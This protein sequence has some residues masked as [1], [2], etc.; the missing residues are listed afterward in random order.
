MTTGGV[1]S[2]VTVQP[3]RAVQGDFAS[4]NPRYTFDAG[5]GGVVA[6]PNGLTIGLFAWLS[7]Q[8]IDSDGAPAYANNN[9]S[10]PV[11]GLVGRQEQG[12]NTTYLSN[13]GMTIQAGFECAIFTAVDMWVV[14]NGT[15]TA[16]PGMKAYANFTNGQASF[17]VP[18]AP[19]TTTQ[20]SATV[21]AGT[22]A[23]FTGSISGNVLT[24]SSA[25]VNTLYLG[26]LLGGTGLTGLNTGVHIVA[27]LSGTFGAAGSTYALDQ[28]ELNIASEAMT[29]TPYTAAGTGGAGIVVGSVIT[30]TSTGASGTVVGAQV[31]AIITAGT[32]VVV[33]MPGAGTGTNTTATL[34]FAQNVETSW[35]CRSQGLAGE[36]VKISNVPALG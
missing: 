33:A 1:Q 7:F 36:L 15:T 4:N 27:L 23:T 8:G 2:Q 28:S 11:A 16:V 17:A 24:I 26:A 13:A 6:G 21:T 18:G 31:T 22:A 12:L 3:A 30:A 5:S 34:T 9:G 25:V 10:G 19:T 14:N 29:A 35:Y 20:T 32:S